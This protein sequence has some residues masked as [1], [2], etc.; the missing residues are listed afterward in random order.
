MKTIKFT[1]QYDK[2]EKSLRDRQ[3]VSRIRIRL[4]RLRNG[5][6]GQIRN[7]HGGVVEMKVDFGPGYRVYYTERDGYLVILLCGGTKKGQDKD[8]ALAVEMAKEI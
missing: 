6:P 5:N 4:D 3:A 8:I 1:P 7:L 2:W